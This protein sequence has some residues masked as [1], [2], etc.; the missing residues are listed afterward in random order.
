[1]MS[2]NISSKSVWMFVIVLLMFVLVH[3]VKMMRLYL[4]FLEEKIEL[5]RFICAYM[6]TTLVNLIIPF[7]LGEAYRMYVFS[8]ITRSAYIGIFG[9]IV[10]RF[11]D[12]MALVILLLLLQLVYPGTV[13][14]VSII[15]FAGIVT[16]VCI[17]LAFMPSYKYL[18]R[19]IIMNRS[20][21]RSMA[22]LKGLEK[23]KGGY[24]YIKKLIMGRY[25]M[26]SLMSVF[27]WGLE[28][29]LLMVLAKAIGVEFKGNDFAQYIASIMSN[30]YSSSV[31]S[32]YTLVSIS[33]MVLFTIISLIVWG[34]SR[35]RMN[36]KNNSNI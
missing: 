12:T 8:A 28:G 1:M 32:V 24:E 30:S 7:K 15:L 10:D 18:N 22:V 21:K 27:A 17:Y 16:I 23:A 35:G 13:N 6:R 34:I 25:A 33:W 9:V 20:S 31:K 14:F 5:K 11:F 36:E 2:I 3:F 19:Y 26:M 4:V 29:V